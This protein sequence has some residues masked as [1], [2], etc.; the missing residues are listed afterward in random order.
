MNNRYLK[1]K[2]VSNVNISRTLVD[3]NF[4]FFCY[5]ITLCLN[6]TIVNCMF[7]GALVFSM[8]VSALSLVTKSRT[9]STTRAGN[10]TKMAT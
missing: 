9:V 4:S 1:Q 6:V 2:I 7:H 8:A 10:S 3:V 5:P